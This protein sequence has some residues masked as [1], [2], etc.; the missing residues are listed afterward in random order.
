MIDLSKFNEQQYLA[1]TS[2]DPYLKIIAGA[3]SGKTSVLT[4]RIAYLVKERN[5]NEKNILAITFTNKAANEMKE[6]VLKLLEKEVF[7]GVIT[8][9]HSFCLRVLREDINV[10]DYKKDFIIIDSDD[11]KVL[12]KQINKK[13]NYDRDLFNTRSIIAYISNQ[14]NNYYPD[15]LD[16][17]TKKV[18]QE[19]YVAY[20]LEM[21]E[22]N[23]L[24]FDDLIIKCVE[25]FKNH[26]R[27]LDKWR[28]RF[29]YIHVDEFQDTN[30]VQYELVKLLGQDLN[31]FVV[32]D[33]D[34][35][36][37]TWRGARIDYIMNFEKDFVPTTLIKLEYN[38]RSQQAI[39]DCANSLIIKNTN[40]IEKSLLPT[41]IKKDQVVHYVGENASDE[42]D[43]VVDKINELINENDDINYDD[44]AILYRSNY[45]SRIFE[46]RL[47]Q[48]NIDYQIIGG[49]KFFERKEIK[50]VLAY[51]KV[52]AYEDD[53]S[54][55]RIINTPKRKIG[56]VSINK[57]VDYANNYH[58]SY[59]Q[60]IKD[61]LND[62]K[63]GAK[64]KEA[65]IELVDI[66][67]SLK[68]EAS[69]ALI[70]NY[71]IENINVLEEYQTIPLEYQKREENIKELYNYSL[72][73]N[74]DIS[75]FLQDISLDSSYEDVEGHRVNLM[76]MHRAKGLEFKYVFVV[77]L[78][79]GIFPS[80]YS[81][82]TLDLEEERRLAYVSFTRA[83]EKLFLLSHL[84]DERFYRISSSLFVKEIEDEFLEKQGKF[85]QDNHLKP[86]VE[87]MN[88]FKEKNKN[89]DNHDY[90]VNDIV[91]HPKFKR[92]VVID[93]SDNVLTIAFEHN[94]GIK[95]I[96][97]SFVE[98][99]NKT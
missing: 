55:L 85:V 6:R 43:Y 83:K 65:L 39:L 20:E 58:L 92:G 78:C 15:Y 14:K 80:M 45:I 53:I 87:E 26:P 75:E 49:T 27:I 24:D 34:Q 25:L 86:I 94:Y 44:F 5:V 37:Y 98:K 71:I 47:L 66:I 76:S 21:K 30:E 7:L 46:Q 18:Y 59:Y 36:I 72:Q 28:Y 4:N 79:D 96:A 8:T 57:I 82:D 77:Y 89:N 35:T 17:Y 3:G 99:E 52:I 74:K 69:S 31:V 63:L 91:I 22:N 13:L 10:L 93:V 70:I 95:K 81:L 19:F 2:K 16:E 60:V 73:E 29:N 11:Q 61:Y 67:E 48:A 23:Y 41:I 32:G 50:D 97:A 56:E 42:A 1:I 51:L 90:N 12:L 54:L 9:F 38:Y 62:I 88:I 33:P 84:Y 40:R 64:Q 68:N